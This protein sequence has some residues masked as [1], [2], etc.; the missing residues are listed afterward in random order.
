MLQNQMTF[1]AV[2]SCE[3]S[4]QKFNSFGGKAIDLRSQM[5]RKHQRKSNVLSK[6]TDQQATCWLK[7]SHF[8]R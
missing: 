1:I 6:Y 3:F 2:L 7:I 4:S 5:F 8:A